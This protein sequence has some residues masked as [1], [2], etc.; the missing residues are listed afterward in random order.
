VEA[1]AL[2]TAD[3]PARMRGTSSLADRYS[4]SGLAGED[5]VISTVA[6][7]AA[8]LVLLGRTLPGLA[9]VA[10]GGVVARI[11]ATTGTFMLPATGTR[12][13]ERRAGN[14]G[15]SRCSEPPPRRSTTAHA[16]GG[17]GTAAGR[18]PGLAGVTVAG[19][20][21]CGSGT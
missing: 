1:A 2:V 7:V 18:G 12:S 13:D 14:A 4:C 10:P 20:L 9:A 3:C 21:A 5:V 17:R 11:P 19:G 16:A 15:P 8:S 6:S